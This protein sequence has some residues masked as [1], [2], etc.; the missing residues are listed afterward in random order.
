MTNRHKDELEKELEVLMT[1]KMTNKTTLPIE[2]KDNL[3]KGGLFHFF[4]KN[5]ST[6]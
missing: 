1:M 4:K 2:T 5:L 3:D 6:L